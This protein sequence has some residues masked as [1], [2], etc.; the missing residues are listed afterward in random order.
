[1]AAGNLPVSAFDAEDRTVEAL[2]HPD[3]RF[4]IAMQWHPGDQARVDPGQL[5]IFR[6]FGAAIG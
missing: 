3:R 6:S 4:V 5:K 2:E 1:M